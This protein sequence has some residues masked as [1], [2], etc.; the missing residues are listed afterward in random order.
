[1]RVKNT[2]DHLTVQAIGGSH[3][4]LLGWDFSQREL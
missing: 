1:M 4:V 3:V 2:S